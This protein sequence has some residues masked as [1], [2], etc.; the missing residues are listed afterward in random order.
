MVM[1]Y[2]FPL[3]CLVAP[4]VCI[5]DAVKARS[6]TGIRTKLTLALVGVVLSYSIALI[7]LP[8]NPWFDD[9]GVREFIT[10]RYRWAW[11]TEL[12][13]WLALPVVSVM[14]GLHALVR[15]VRG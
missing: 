3:A 15:A 6:F 5:A 14:W 7:V 12:A 9:N 11:A 8:F 2:L 4:D 10:W 13:G 1:L